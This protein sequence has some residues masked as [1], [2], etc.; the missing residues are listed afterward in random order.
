MSQVHSKKA[1]KSSKYR[2]VSWCSKLQMWRARIKANGRCEHLGYFSDEAAA[3]KAYDD[4]SIEVN[5]HVGYVNFP[6]DALNK[7]QNKS[8]SENAIA[9]AH[10]QTQTIQNNNNNVAV[11]GPR[12]PLLQLQQVSQN[13]FVFGQQ[14]QQIQQQQQNQQ[15]P[16]MLWSPYGSMSSVYHDQE[17][18]LTR[19]TK[20]IR[21]D[22]GSFMN[23]TNNMPIQRVDQIQSL[24]SN[25][26]QQQ[27]QS[28]LQNRMRLQLINPQ[29]LSPMKQQ[30]ILVPLHSFPYLCSP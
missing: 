1:I 2:G 12:T 10:K 8:S 4:R 7:M 11:E 28:L 13:S 18:N 9:A 22:L 6:A 14:H 26:Q 16:R 20:R 27:Q 21:V 25:F 29:L 23:N 19:P 17:P 5:S 30:K 3:A 15:Q 24:I